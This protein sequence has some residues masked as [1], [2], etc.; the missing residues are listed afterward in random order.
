MIKDRNLFTEDNAGNKNL[1]LFPR[2][3]ELRKEIYFK[4]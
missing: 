2:E 3:L 4:N 1:M